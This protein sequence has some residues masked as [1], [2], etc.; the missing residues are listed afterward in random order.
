MKPLVSTIYNLPQLLPLRK[1]GRNYHV[2]KAS[3]TIL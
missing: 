2:E 3:L 1:L